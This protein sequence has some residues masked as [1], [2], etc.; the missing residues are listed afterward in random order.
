MPAESLPV[1]I[2]V[3]AMFAAFIVV[4]SA[5]AVWTHQADTPKKAKVAAQQRSDAGERSSTLSNAR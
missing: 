4:L 3:I 5:V 1:I 2:L